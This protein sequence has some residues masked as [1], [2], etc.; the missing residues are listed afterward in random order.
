MNLDGFLLYIVAAG[1]L[2]ASGF[3][4]STAVILGNIFYHM[5][6]LALAALPAYLFYKIYNVKEKKK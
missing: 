1:L 2:L 3:A 4:H 6:G 5:I